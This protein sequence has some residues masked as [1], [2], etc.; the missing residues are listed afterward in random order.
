MDHV[1][2]GGDEGGAGEEGEPDFLD[3][4]VEGDGEA[5]EDA[6]VGGLGV[7]AGFG[8]DEVAGGAMLD[9]DALGAAGGAGGV[10]DVGKVARGGGGVGA[11]EAKGGLAGDGVAVAVEENEARPAR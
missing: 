5:L 11:G 10:D 9:H 6:V 7:E 3:A 8:A 2:G 1:G 4:G